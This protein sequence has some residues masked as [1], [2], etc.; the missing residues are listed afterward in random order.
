MVE[1]EVASPG[2]LSTITVTSDH[3]STREHPTGPPAQPQPLD[4]G[5]W[6][7]TVVEATRPRSSIHHQ[8]TTAALPYVVC[9]IGQWLISCR[10]RMHP[11]QLCG[12]QAVRLLKQM[13]RLFHDGHFNFTTC[14]DDYDD[15]IVL[16]SA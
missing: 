9:R 1:G 8:C 12:P 13:Q 7:I 14:F 3:N 10:H 16:N 2:L 5:T 15:V 11:M 4:T 6:R